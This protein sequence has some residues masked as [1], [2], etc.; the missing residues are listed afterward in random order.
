M[1]L[2]GIAEHVWTLWAWETVFCTVNGIQ[3]LPL[4]SEGKGE[5]NFTYLLN[6]YLLLIMWCTCVCTL[7]SAVPLEANRSQLKVMFSL[8]EGYM[9]FPCAW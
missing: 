4:N 3:T 8:A 9:V 1:H 7:M 6:I 2:T 5:L